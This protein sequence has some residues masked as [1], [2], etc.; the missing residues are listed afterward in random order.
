MYKN[1]VSL[2]T[3]FILYVLQLQ[4]PGLGSTFFVV[5]F[6]FAFN[7]NPKRIQELLLRHIT[8]GKKL[9]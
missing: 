1:N 4:K 3:Q 7:K 2:L 6:S 8:K 9:N 5:C